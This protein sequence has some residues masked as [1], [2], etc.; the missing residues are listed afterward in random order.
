MRTKEYMRSIC[1]EADGAL[2]Y[3][4]KSVRFSSTRPEFG[5]MYREMALDEL[6]HARYLREIGQTMM[7]EEKNPSYETEKSWLRC[8]RHL[9]EQET[10]VTMLL[11]DKQVVV[12]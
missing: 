5:K 4:Q 6:K 8:I 3:A 11:E 9:V 7:N 1:D 12:V 2:D 10:A